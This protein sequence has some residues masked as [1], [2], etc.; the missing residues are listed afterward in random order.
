MRER[1]RQLGGEME[2]DSPGQGTAVHVI[3]PLG[4]AA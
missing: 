4:E 1:M 2:I 3:L